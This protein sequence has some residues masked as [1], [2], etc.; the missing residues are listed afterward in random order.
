[1]ANSTALNVHVHASLAVYRLTASVSLTVDGALPRNSRLHEGLHHFVH[2]G[3]K[4]P[5]TSSTRS[6]AGGVSTSGHDSHHPPGVAGGHD[7]SCL[8]GE[9]TAHALRNSTPV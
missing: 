6:S 8:P 4:G 7:S 9:G 2:T 3:G 1:M 5:V